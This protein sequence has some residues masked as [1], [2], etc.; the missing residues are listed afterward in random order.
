MVNSSE[1]HSHTN[2]TNWGLKGPLPHV[3]YIL[4]ILRQCLWG[5]PGLN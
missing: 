4:Y 1:L 2:H 5:L 3:D